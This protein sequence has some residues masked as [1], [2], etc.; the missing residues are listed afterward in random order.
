M[1]ENRTRQR[2]ETEA[3]VLGYA[4]SRLDQDYLAARNCSTWKHA[5]TEAADALSKPRST[6]KNLRDEFDPVHDN[7]RQGWH[8][9]NMR[10]SRIR[11]LDE[12]HDVSD[13]A[14]IELVDR[15]LKRD[16]TST[17]EA[18][19]SLAAVNRVAYNVADRLVTG[20]L[21]EEYFM[22]NSQAL[23]DV[24]ADRLVDRRLSGC[25]YDFEIQDLPAR[26]LEIKGLKGN[27][28]SVLFTEREWTEARAR[29]EDYWV[30]VI[31]NLQGSPIH[32]IFP[33]PHVSLA[34]QSRFRQ[35]LVLSW[36]ASVRI[37]SP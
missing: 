24:S 34:A 20:R 19:D 9:R 32:A 15:I 11:V 27:S 26:A 10:S 37:S 25:G 28:G 2:L 7:S 23:I 36:H 1:S 22:A 5:F 3:I 30:V 33:D 17:G 21:A 29:K 4:M 18:I 16:D 13:V 14:L 8:H 35:S 12:L 31:G 6:F